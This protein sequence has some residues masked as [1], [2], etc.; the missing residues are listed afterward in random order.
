M[1]ASEELSVFLKEGWID[2][3]PTSVREVV[4]ARSRSGTGE[5]LFHLRGRYRDGSE[6]EIGHV[7]V[8]FQ[9]KDDSIEVGGATIYRGPGMHPVWKP[10]DPLLLESP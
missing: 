5:V 7:T 3:T 8:H 10:K 1:A 9:M 4:H 6:E 2:F